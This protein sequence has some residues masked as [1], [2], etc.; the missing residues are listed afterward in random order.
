[1]TLTLAEA[2]SMLHDTFDELSPRDNATD[3]AVQSVSSLAQPRVLAGLLSSLRSDTQVIAGCAAGSYHHPLGFDKL[4]LIDAEPRFMLRLHAWWPGVVRGVE[5]VHNHRF[6][7]ATSVVAGG[8][9]MEVYR[10]ATTGV[11]M[12]EYREELSPGRA[13]WRLTPRGVRHLRPVASVRIGAGSGYG[14]AANTLHRVLVPRGE[15]CVTLFLETLIVR[16]TTR[17]FA[18]RHRPAPAFTQKQAF[19][20]AGYLQRVDAILSALPG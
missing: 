20:S 11:P 7:L 13:D 4:A 2:A 14:L 18:E 1:M 19:D 6:G 12:D 5:H 8:Y 10:L 16:S 17:V 3:L 15:L 9:D